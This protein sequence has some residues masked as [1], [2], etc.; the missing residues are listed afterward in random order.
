[1]GNLLGLILIG[2]AIGFTLF[3]I[4]KLIKAGLEDRREYDKDQK[5]YLDNYSEDLPYPKDRE[6]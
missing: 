2:I 6:K 5:E 4:Y 1:M 3:V